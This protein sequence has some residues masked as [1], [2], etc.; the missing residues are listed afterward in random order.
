MRQ[1][2]SR[3]HKYRR[4]T[5]NLGAL[6]RVFRMYVRYRPESGRY[7]SS[8][9]RAGSSFRFVRS[10]DAPKTTKM[11]GSGRRLSL[12]LRSTGRNAAVTPISAFLGSSEL[13]VDRTEPCAIPV[14]LF[15]VSAAFSKKRETFKQFDASAEFS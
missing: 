2:G 12:P 3:F 4:L 5:R 10:P 11:Q 1:Q 8:G 9:K 14:H 6:E 7:E 15:G 13:R